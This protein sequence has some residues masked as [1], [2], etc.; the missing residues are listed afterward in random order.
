LY[1][2][3]TLSILNYFWFSLKWEDNRIGWHEDDVNGGL[4]KYSKELIIGPNTESCPAEG[5]SGL[6]WLVPLCGKTVDMAYLALQEE[7]TAHVVGV[8]GIS[9]ALEEFAKDHPQLEIKP[10]NT[11]DS[12]AQ[13]NGNKITLLKGDF[14]ALDE[15]AT[16]GR[17]DAVMDRGSMVA[18]DPSLREHYVQTMSKLVKPG[19]KILLVT[20]ERRTGEEEKLKAGPPFSISEPEVCRLY[21]SQEW[22]ESVQLLEEF[23][24][25][26]RKPE[27][28]ERYE[29]V[30]SMYELYFLISR[31][32]A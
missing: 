1:L 24:E 4:V 8:D 31:K 25:F 7:T 2:N 10:D 29:G 21:E 16:G 18:I 27:K 15:H 32:K 17:F 19:G 22:V 28:R 26:E 14:F 13:W 23:D 30:T 5:G 3:M 9:I 11:I 20:L 12:F 6:R